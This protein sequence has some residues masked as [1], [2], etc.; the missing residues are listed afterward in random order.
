MNREPTPGALPGD[1]DAA[2]ALKTGGSGTRTGAQLLARLDRLPAWPYSRHVVP[3]VAAILFLAVYDSLAI[4][5]VLPAIEREFGVSTSAAAMSIT[6]NQIGGPIGAY[7]LGLAAEYYGRKRMILLSTGLYTVGIGATA[8]SFNLGWFIFWQFF[9]GAGITG[10]TVIQSALVSELAPAKARGRSEGRVATIGWLAFP[11]L[12]IISMLLIPIPVWGW[13][14]FY[15]LGALAGVIT[16]I[17]GFSKLPESA[18]WLVNKGHYRE[19]EAQLQRSEARLR[20]KGVEL[21]DPVLTQEE[22]PPARFATSALFKRPYR[23][24]L[25][26]TFLAWFAF[27]LANKGWATLAPTLLLTQGFTVGK[28]FGFL[29]VTN[30]TYPIGAFVSTRIGDRGQ[31]KWLAFAAAVGWALSFLVMSLFPSGPVIMMIGALG[32]FFMAFILVLMYTLTAESFPTRARGNGV[33]LTNGVGHLGGAAAPSLIIGV[34]VA[35]AGY[36]GG[37][38]VIV[39]SIALTALLMLFMVRATGRPLQDI[40]Q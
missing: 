27:Y 5:Y 10:V 36:A 13:R 18:R 25:A 22:R 11:L 26:I 17:W 3:I 14:T 9:V 24:R 1:G 40:S 16:M 34:G 2:F 28:S 19:A 29:F 35:T 20:A 37:M 31:R 8:L 32:T 30:L 39:G 6:V 23:A 12:P 38:L 15:L 33:G 7:L 21:P 4:G